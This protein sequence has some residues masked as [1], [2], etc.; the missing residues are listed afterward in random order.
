MPKIRILLAT[1]VAAALGF[2]IHV[3]YG[4]GLAMDYVQSAAQAGRLNDII[5]QPYPSW[6]VAVAAITALIPTLGKVLLYS[7]IQDKLPA[8]GPM[9][10]GLIF[11]LVLLMIDDALLRTPIMMSVVGTPV[12]VLLIQSLEGWVIP[13]ITGL[14]IASIVPGSL[15]AKRG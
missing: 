11:G 10:R 6:L 1:I 3:I 12:D 13:V 8:S 9:A 15:S 14:V 2:S 5:R 4:Q 7:L